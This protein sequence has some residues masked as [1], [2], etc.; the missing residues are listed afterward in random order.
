MVTRRR[1]TNLKPV[2]ER[3]RAV[4]LL[5]ELLDGKLHSRRSIA[6]RLRVSLRT[7]DRWMEALERLPGI[8]RVPGEAVIRYAPAGAA[9]RDATTVVAALA[10]SLAGAFGPSLTARGIAGVAERLLDGDAEDATRKFVLLA[11]ADE[12]A[13]IPGN[14]IDALVA[15]VARSRV[16][17][18]E[19][20]EEGVR[21]QCRVQPLSVA[22]RGGRLHL[23]AR[24]CTGGPVTAYAVAQI[25]RVVVEATGFEY[26]S[27]AEYDPEH[28]EIDRD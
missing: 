28:V 2:S 17:R 14:D 10:R 1:M 7:A 23:L 13:A 12:G 25:A 27:P 15:A 22:V 6:E 8:T 4:L 21:F 24:E 26:P 16:V 19:Y 11:D 5:G 9:S 20:C 18:F 3:Q